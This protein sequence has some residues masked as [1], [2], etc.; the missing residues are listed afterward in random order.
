M[1]SVRINYKRLQDDLQIP[2]GHIP[3]LFKKL[4]GETISKPAVYAWFL[5]KSMPMERL[6]QLLTVVR[7]ESGRRLDLWTYIEVPKPNKK[8]A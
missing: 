2:L 6:A 8:A 1:Y 7:L 3:E 5:R 4:F